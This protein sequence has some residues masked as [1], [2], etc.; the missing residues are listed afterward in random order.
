MICCQDG[1]P[2]LEKS[3]VDDDF[4]ARYLSDIELAF[5]LE[6][7]LDY[8]RHLRN[9]KRVALTWRLIAD[10]ILCHVFFGP[11]VIAY[12]RGVWD[13][14]LMYSDKIFGVKLI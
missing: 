9:E 8:G 3:P 14:S 5:G 1:Q 6:I 10:F 7:S 2:P 11:F 12:W 13:Y 4:T